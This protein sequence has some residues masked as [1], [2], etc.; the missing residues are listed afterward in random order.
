MSGK[1]MK[2]G[3]IVE[4]DAAH[5]LPHLLNKCKNLH[6]HT[7]KVEIQ[8]KGESVNGMV[9]DFHD[10]KHDIQFLIDRLDHS[11]LNDIIQIPTAENLCEYIYQNIP[12]R[13]RICFLRV[14]ESSSTYAEMSL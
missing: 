2:V 5:K 4:F 1:I 7:Y 6:G 8:V 3:L 9:I 14:W 10:L 12:F 11:Y 13:D